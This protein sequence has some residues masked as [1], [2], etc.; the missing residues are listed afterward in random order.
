MADAKAHSPSI[1]LTSIAGRDVMFKQFSD[2]LEAPQSTKLEKLIWRLRL[3]YDRQLLTNGE[4]ECEAFNGDPYLESL[5][6]KLTLFQDTFGES[7]LE[8]TRLAQMPKLAR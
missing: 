8:R 1:A 3:A 5:L 2:F 7:R 6:R 4:A